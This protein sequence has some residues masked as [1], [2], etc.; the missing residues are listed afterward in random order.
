V[1]AWASKG[2]LPE[3]LVGVLGDALQ[4]DLKVADH[5]I[6]PGRLEQVGV[7]LK[8]RHQAPGG[9]HHR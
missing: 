5:A 8:R 4:Q 1:A 7:V 2:Q 9:L 6:D 3:A